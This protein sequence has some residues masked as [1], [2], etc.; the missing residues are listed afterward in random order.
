MVWSVQ[1]RSYYFVEKRSQEP[2]KHLRFSLCEKGPYSEFFWFIFSRIWTSYRE[3]R[4][5]SPYSVRMRE[6]TNQKKSEYGHFPHIV[7][8]FARV[9]V[10]PL[11]SHMN[12]FMNIRALALDFLTV[13]K[14]CFSVKK[15]LKQKVGRISEVSNL[16]DAKIKFLLIF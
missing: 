13:Y 14:S 12:W 1:N 7:Y 16:E 11:L 3:I 15:C 2:Y 8:M 9:L 10:A 5:I 6:N 4:S